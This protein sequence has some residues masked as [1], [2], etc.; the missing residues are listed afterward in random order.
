MPAI[1]CG[2]TALYK[3]SPLTP[4]TST[5]FAEILVQVGLPPGVLNI[6]Q[7]GAVVGE[8]LCTHPDIAKVS[9]TGSVET[10]VKVKIQVYA[11]KTSTV[12]FL[13]CSRHYFSSHNTAPF[14]FGPS[15]LGLAIFSSNLIFFTVKENNYWWRPFSKGVFYW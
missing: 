8:A 15:I 1:A 6:V 5:L 2:N 4:L 7:G 14:N 3:P 9:F 13:S 12:T 10:G 11:I